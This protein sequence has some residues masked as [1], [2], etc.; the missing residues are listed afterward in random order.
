MEIIEY[1]PWRDSPEYIKEFEELIL[2]TIE[3]DSIIKLNIYSSE[4]RKHFHK[5]AQSNGLFHV[6]YCDKEKDFQINR[7]Y[8]CKEC[9]KY[10]KKKDYRIQPCCGDGQCGEY[11]VFCEFRHDFDDSDD[12]IIIIADEGGAYDDVPAKETKQTNNIIAISN[13]IELLSDI[14]EK[15]KI[16]KPLQWIKKREEKMD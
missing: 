7:S 11:L 2:K 16:K 15:K 5:F 13:K 3:T 12:D 1:M 6:S 14:F 8:W 4:T 10:I 9:E